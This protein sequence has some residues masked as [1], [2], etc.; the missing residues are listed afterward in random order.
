MLKRMALLV[1]VSTTTVVSAGALSGTQ[2]DFKAG[3]S[4]WDG[5][6]KTHFTDSSVI[7]LLG[8]DSLIYSTNSFKDVWALG[9][10]VQT[11]IYG[12]YLE[13]INHEFTVKK[14]KVYMSD[15]KYKYNF[16]RGSM[17][18][19]KKWEG[20]NW[21]FRLGGGVRAVTIGI[22]KR[23]GKPPFVISSDDRENFVM[24]EIRGVFSYKI[25]DNWKTDFTVSAGIHS[26][27][28]SYSVSGQ[29]GYFL[30]DTFGLSFGVQYEKIKLDS[31]KNKANFR[32]VM[33]YV[34]FT[35]FIK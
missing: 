17:G 35:T 30:T 29:I 5:Y 9:V 10:F 25:S 3:Y 31:S 18:L 14:S 7:S 26:D 33:P 6:A 24:P 32:I 34:S 16:G 20:E 11:D 15:V 8:Q 27:Y 19:S 1:F 12:Y 4:I 13:G 28:Q 2:V 21:L 23:I 22:D